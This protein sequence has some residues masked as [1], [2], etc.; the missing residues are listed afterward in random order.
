MLW[1][2]RCS[3]CCAKNK[4]RASP[5][6]TSESRSQPVVVAVQESVQNPSKILRVNP[7]ILPWLSGDCFRTTRKIIKKNIKYKI[8]NNNFFLKTLNFQVW[9]N[10]I[11]QG[12]FLKNL[13]L[14]LLVFFS[15]PHSP[16]RQ[17]EKVDQGPNER[18][19]R[20][21]HHLLR[22]CE[23]HP[24]MPYF[25]PLHI[26]PRQAACVPVEETEGKRRG[27]GG[28]GAGRMLEVVWISPLRS[29]CHKRNTV[30]HA[31]TPSRTHTFTL[32]H[33]AVTSCPDPSQCL[34]FFLSFPL[35]SPSLP[36][37]SFPSHTLKPWHISEKE[38]PSPPTPH[39]PSSLSSSLPDPAPRGASRKFSHICGGALINLR[40]YTPKPVM[41][42]KS[43]GRSK[44]WWNVCLIFL[45]RHNTLLALVRKLWIS[46]PVSHMKRQIF[47]FAYSSG[48][49]LPINPNFSRRLP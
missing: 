25:K 10:P 37:F 30:S 2:V 26:S 21:R 29:L 11:R 27:G 18:G 31:H 13:F 45:K 20:R 47:L 6:N 5:L 8:N 1:I 41:E 46:I 22:L 34:T 36:A 12:F 42:Q 39:L 9:T 17:T 23:Q 48:L 43:C 35:F 44:S 14:Y 40:R 16:S 49:S 28:S 19:S 3:F 7:L 32:Q 15:A 33:R 38:S 4:N 24:R